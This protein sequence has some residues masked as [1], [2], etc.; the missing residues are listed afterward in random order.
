MRSILIEVQMDSS[1]STRKTVF[2]LYSVARSILEERIL[3]YGQRSWMSCILIMGYCVSI[4]RHHAGSLPRWKSL[5]EDVAWCPL[6]F[7]L[8]L[9]SRNLM[10]VKRHVL[11]NATH[12]LLCVLSILPSVNKGNRSKK[13]TENV[14]S[15]FSRNCTN[16]MF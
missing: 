5:D 3:E 7:Y 16:W 6:L 4:V 8:F 11:I 10:R 13:K 15:E 14:G 12:N 1:F 2:S 9:V